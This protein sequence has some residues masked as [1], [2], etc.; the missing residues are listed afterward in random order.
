MLSTLAWK[1]RLQLAL[2]LSF[3]GRQAAMPSAGDAAPLPPADPTSLSSDMECSCGPRPSSVTG[4][5][6]CQRAAA[7]REC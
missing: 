6:G 7:W 5:A 2:S 4:A 1:A 3:M